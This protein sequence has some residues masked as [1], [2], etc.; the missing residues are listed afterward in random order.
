MFL[1]SVEKTKIAVHRSRIH[2]QSD[3]LPNFVSNPFDISVRSSTRNLLATDFPDLRTLLRNCLSINGKITRNSDEKLVLFE[4]KLP[5]RILYR[6]RRFDND[7]TNR[8][9]FGS[10]ASET[11]E[12]TG[13]RKSPI[14]DD[15]K[16]VHLNYGFEIYG[17]LK[18]DG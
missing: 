9:S 5:K 6:D 11:T 16:F 15:W 18:S 8:V 3:F 7:Q 17:P 14:S 10:A 13:S 2:D 12:P 4:E 1:L